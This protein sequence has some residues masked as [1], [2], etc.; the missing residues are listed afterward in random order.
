MAILE[1]PFECLNCSKIFFYKHPKVCDNC[2][3][4][5]FKFSPKN[6]GENNEILK[7]TKEEVKILSQHLMNEYLTHEEP[8]R[9]VLLK[10]HQFANK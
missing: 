7:L 10:I 5:E 3:Y 2:G 4:T 9:S 1:A 6:L 8:A